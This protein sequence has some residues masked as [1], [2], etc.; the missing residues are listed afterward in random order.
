MINPF[1]N[2]SYVDIE[3]LKKAVEISI[4]A[5]NE[6]LIEGLP[7][8]PL[9]EQRDSVRDWRQIG[10]GTMG[11]ADMLIK[12]GITYGSNES[13]KYIED[14]FK[15]I[16]TTAVKSSLQLAKEDTCYPKC[17]K[18]KLIK[19]SFIKKLDLPKEILDEIEIYGLYNS[20]L[21]TCAPTGSIATMLETSTGVEPLFALE[22]TRK[23]QSLNGQD[24]YYK[25]N[26][27]IVQDYINTTN[28]NLLPDYFIIS[29]QINP[30][31]RIKVQG[32]MQKFIDASISS[33][34]NLPKETTIE[35]VYNIYIKAWEHGLKGC[36]VY[37]SGCN[38]DAILL[39]NDKEE[40]KQE[41]STK[42][43]KR[44]EVIKAGNNWIGLKRTLMSGCGTLH[45]CAY[46]DSINGELRECYLS[47]GSLGGCQNFMIGLSRMISLSAR[48][49]LSINSIVDQLKSCGVCPSYAVRTATKKDTSKGSCCPV[50]VGNALL[51]MYKE[52]QE[53]LKSK[54]E[55][56]TTIEIVKEMPKE[57]LEECPNCHEKSLTRQ[58]GCFQ[59]L[60]CGFSRCE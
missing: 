59:C 41:S 22:Y 4:R 35:D 29:S 55:K 12:L 45:C 15:I 47:K 27:K 16:A 39:T 17:E 33:T 23:T 58:G 37:R 34:I 10:L 52:I 25:V 24:T 38:R 3:S 14:L 21:L 2:N 26:T 11:L 20:Q 30:I 43:L 28:N 5:L 32:G 36:T 9:K 1:T 40:N 60:S 13:L 48:G 18:S 57:E 42:E 19:S 44:G 46:F 54:T 51:D 7:L 8:H 56:Q 6:V 53:T 50:A 49:G 31:D